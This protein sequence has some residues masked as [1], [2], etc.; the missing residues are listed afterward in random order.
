[1]D[2]ESHLDSETHELQSTPVKNIIILIDHDNIDTSRYDPRSIVTAALHAIPDVADG[3]YV[4][5]RAYGGWFEGTSP[6]ES[7]FRALVSYQNLCPTLIRT[8]RG[9]ARIIFEFA[10]ELALSRS[11]RRKID[12]R[13][14]VTVR[15][16]ADPIV[17]CRGAMQCGE[18]DCQVREVRKWA[19]R[20]NACFS[21]TC[22]HPFNAFFQ[23]RQQKQVDVHLA[24]DLVWLA[25]TCD[26]N[27]AIVMASDDTDLLPA[28]LQASSQNGT[29]KII[30]LRSHSDPTTSSDALLAR[31]G[32]IDIVL[33]EESR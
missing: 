9:L 32:I 6:T 27:T 19:R 17:A 12:I 4:T 11:H 10:D 14:T 7:R 33:K 25:S 15:R 13:Y 26:Q 30:R 16:T 5:L 21:P 29:A 28:L 23:R 3:V 8:D 24:V 1:M 18:V 31:R 22:P 2:Q 20:K